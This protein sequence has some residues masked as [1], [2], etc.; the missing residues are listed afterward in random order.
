MLMR[1]LTFLFCLTISACGNEPLAE[2]LDSHYQVAAK[3]TTTTL[4]E[5]ING[6]A[7][8]TLIVA[9]GAKN[10]EILD[11]TN[12]AQ[13]TTQ[14]F[15]VTIGPTPSSTEELCDTVIVA[16]TGATAA[17]DLALLASNG[18]ELPP[19]QVAIGTK[20]FTP[21]NLAA[22]GAS[23]GAPGNAYMAYIRTQHAEILTVDPATDEIHQIGMLQADQPDRWQQRVHVEVREASARYPQLSLVAGNAKAPAV[24]QAKQLLLKG[25]RV[26][27]IATS[28]QSITKAI[29]ATAA[30]APNGPAPVIVL[31]PMLLDHQA[32]VIGCSPDAIAQA[33]AAS[34]RQLLPEGGS[35]IVCFDKSENLVKSFCQV[36]GFPSERLLTR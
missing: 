33:A 32:C 22:G 10:Q 4:T 8:A 20:T 11:R 28:N 1:S 26:L 19:N 29:V 18:V 24:D 3:C 30:S 36:M 23:R 16:E 7:D 14:P 34:I 25:C 9:F 31:D 21:A 6:T 12:A 35:M 13:R 5:S 2:D 27:M 17:V 15:V